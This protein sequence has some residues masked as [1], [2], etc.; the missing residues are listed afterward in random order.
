MAQIWSL[1]IDSPNACLYFHNFCNFLN[2]I[3][4]HSSVYHL[5][6][7]NEKENYGKD[8]CLEYECLSLNFE[9]S[10]ELKT[11]DTVIVFHFIFQ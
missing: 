7:H 10:E 1:R 2:N 11:M 9:I 4:Q 5:R 8:K 6:A 3:I